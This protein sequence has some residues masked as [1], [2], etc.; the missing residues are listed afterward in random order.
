MPLSYCPGATTPLALPSLEL[1]GCGRGATDARGM[2]AVH[3]AVVQR[4]VGMLR[5]LTERRGSQ[6]HMHHMGRHNNN[7]GV[8]RERAVVLRPPPPPYGEYGER[9][10][11]L[12]DELCRRNQLGWCALHTAAF[13]GHEVCAVRVYCVHGTHMAA[14][15]AAAAAARTGSLTF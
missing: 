5:L 6:G 13:H 14:S 4:D 2:T 1:P 3:S 8:Q 10:G 7:N 12:L 15:T 11:T 9:G